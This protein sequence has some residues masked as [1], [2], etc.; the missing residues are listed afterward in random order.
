MY[1]ENQATHARAHTHTHTHT[2]THGMGGGGGSACKCAG[3]SGQLK[4][5]SQV[6]RL[7]P[8]AL[9]C[10]LPP[11][12]GL[13]PRSLLSSPVGDT[14]VTHTCVRSI[15]FSFSSVIMCYRRR[16]A[17]SRLSL[18]WQVGFGRFYID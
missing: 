10:W 17:T 3:M 16:V 12:T 5:R 7:R 18:R 2:H 15:D 1:P 9:A 4:V 8:L 14:A 11:L 13:C 6:V